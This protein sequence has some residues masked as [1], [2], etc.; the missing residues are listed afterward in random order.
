MKKKMVKSKFLFRNGILWFMLSAFVSCAQGFDSNEIFQSDVQNA[1]LE[2]PELNESS[3]TSKVNAD[4]SESIQVSWSVV[5][6]ASGY[7]CIVYIVDDPENPEEIYNGIVDGTSFLF[8]KKDDTK[9]EVSVQA[10][11]NETLNNKDAETP[12]VIAYSTLVP[13][14]IIPAGSDIVE[15]VKSHIIDQD[16]EQ[17]FELEAGASYEI[18]SELDFGTKLVTFRGDKLDRPT[19]TFGIDGVIRT[20]AGLKIKFINFDCTVQASKGVVECSSNPPSSLEG[21][22]FAGYMDVAYILKDPIIFQE[23][24]FKNVPRCLFYTGECAWGVEDIRVMDCI[25]QLD[26][27]GTSF[28]DAAVL[29]TYSSTSNYKGSQSWNAAIRNI[30]IKNSTIYNIKPNSKNRMIRFMTNQLGKIFDSQYGTATISD[31]T[32]SKTFTDKEFANNTPNR[33]EY[34]ITFNNNVCY[35]IFRLQKFIQGNCT[36][37]VN[38]STNTIWGDNVEIDNTDKTKWAT[39]ENPNFSGNVTQVLDLTQPNG[40][41]NFKANGTISSTVGDP[42]WLE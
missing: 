38:M 20:S 18:N 28:G 13:A 26:N 12:T 27:D 24:M 32:L 9:Y 37:N 41:I 5:Q 14:Q 4:G 7:K 23:C 6:G 15:F 8:D 30:T 33:K 31:C 1:Q 42:R 25:V 39:E 2:S 35:D 22:N 3:F 34:T 36:N 10:L 21:S 16:T 11:G 29:C 17:A 40:G 19:V